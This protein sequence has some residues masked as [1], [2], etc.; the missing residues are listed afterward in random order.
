MV[1]QRVGR[2]LFQPVPLGLGFQGPVGVEPD[3]AGVA[4]QRLPVLARVPG[5]ARVGRLGRVGVCDG[6]AAK[7][8]GAEHGQLVRSRLVDQESRRGGTPGRRGWGFRPV[9]AC[10]GLS[11]GVRVALFPV[12]A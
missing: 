1:G 3:R 4:G 2:R 11:G 12:M 8:V 6:V 7:L 5:A 9:R 10:P